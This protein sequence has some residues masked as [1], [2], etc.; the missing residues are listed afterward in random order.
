VREQADRSSASELIHRLWYEYGYRYF[1]LRQPSLHNYLEF[2]DYLMALAE[3]CE[4][5]GVSL[6]GFL[7]LLR[8]NMGQYRRLEELEAPVRPSEGVQL[9]T[10]HKAKGLQFPVVILADMGNPGRSAGGFRPYYLSDAFGI[11]LN[12][13]Q[14]NYFSLLGE[15]ETE[16]KE[17]A[18]ARRL[19][20]VA[21]TRARCHLVLAGTLRRSGGGQAHL[22]MVLSA[23]GLEPD[24]MFQRAIQPIEGCRLRIEPIP[25][26]SRRE[27]ESLRPPNAAAKR[28][29]PDPEA[30]AAFYERDPLQRTVRRREYSV[31]QLCEALEPEPGRGEPVFEPALA[32]DRLLGEYELES[33]FGS[34]VHELLARWMA[35]PD[36][37]CPQPEWRHLG[38]APEHRQECLKAAAELARRFLDS[39]LGLR[40]RRDPGRQTELPFLYRWQTRS[41]PLYMSGQMDLVFRGEG[42]TWL[43][44]YK[45]DRSL[46]EGQYDLQLAFY[47]LACA[48]LV[49]EPVQPRIFLLRS[50][51]EAQPVRRFTAAQLL[52]GLPL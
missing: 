47:E 13:G 29:Q 23:L 18:E 28:P 51:R 36:G 43:L 17:L 1:I 21:A 41:G 33:R 48:E 10:I 11:T 22:P 19:L 25:E 39:P 50:G 14:G 20:Y 9:L 16:A 52:E 34:L 35:D 46:R 15:R 45:T 7:E 27:L 37:P 31:S 42:Q 24:T 32:V 4:R 26:V 40:A 12:L 8:Q 49:G 3:R 30:L 6:A 2:Y 44:D 5:Q 38:I